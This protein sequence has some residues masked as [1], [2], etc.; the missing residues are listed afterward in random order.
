MA[1]KTDMER[2]GFF[3]ESGYTTI[4]DPYVSRKSSKHVYALVGCVLK[5]GVLKGTGH[6]SHTYSRYHPIPCENWS[7][8]K[9]KGSSIYMMITATVCILY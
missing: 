4:A 5:C 9:W 7:I 8:V 3:S 6:V 1:A 2:I